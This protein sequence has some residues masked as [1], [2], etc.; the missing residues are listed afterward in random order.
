MVLAAGRAVEDR[1]ALDREF[2]D[3]FVATNLGDPH[4]RAKT[5]RF[6]RGQLDPDNQRYTSDALGGLRRFEQPTLLLWAQNDPHFGLEWAERLRADIPGARPIEILPGCGH[7]LMEEKP[8][9]VADLIGEFLSEEASRSVP[10][11]SAPPQ[12]A[13]DEIL[14][15]I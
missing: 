9:E 7:L 3:G 14:D 4:R 13:F 12:A 6:L 11:R 10:F 1:A 8:L 15:W 5:K 2:I